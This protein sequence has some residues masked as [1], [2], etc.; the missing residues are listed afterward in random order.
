MEAISVIEAI[1]VLLALAYLVLAAYQN[2]WCWFAAAISSIL[3][4]KICFD[5]KLFIET[6]LQFFY[7]IMAIV[8][9]FQWQKNNPS[10]QEESQ[11]INLS[12][13]QW[14]FGILICSIISFVM[15][16]WFQQNTDAKLPWLDAPVTIFSVWATW[17]VIKKVLQN[18][19]LWIVIDSVAIYIYMQR[20]LKITALLYALYTLLAVIG[21][22]KWKKAQQISLK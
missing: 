6:G 21:Y 13:K 2:S 10:V 5:A 9:Y 22:F 14:V 16:F 12:L 20:S 7:L 17:L 8:G 3:Y 15:A 4:I 11:I 19:L 18:W 1:A